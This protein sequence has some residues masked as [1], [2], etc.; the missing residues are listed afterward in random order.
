MG[1]LLMKGLF[2]KENFVFSSM[3]KEQR[4][5]SWIVFGLLALFFIISSFTFVNMLYSF[6]DI[7]GCIVSGSPDVA[8]K[9]L[10]RNLPLFFSFFMTLWVLLAIHAFFRNVSEEQR[11]KSLKKDAIVVL[12]LSLV[13]FFYVVIGRFAGLYSNFAE[14]SPS[15]WFPLDAMLYSLPFIAVSTVTLLDGPALLKDHPYTV[16]SRGPIVTKGRFPYCLFIVLWMLFALYG[17]SGFFMGLFILDF[18]H[19]YLAYS[20]AL[21]LVFLLDASSFIVW[22]LYYNQ[23]KAEKRKELLL[24]LGII[25]V[26]VSVLVA[27]FYFIALGNNL[28][29]P[30]N[31]GFGLLPVAFAAS[32]NIATL[33][34]VATPLI[35]S[36]VALIK[37]ILL[38]KQK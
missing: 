38:K 31:V 27:G 3:D 5:Q 10:V 15:P 16:P 4:K 18:V 30:S 33:L 25:G 2:N 35:A 26:V 34:C 21:L 28:D 36:I 11:M 19:G 6:T 9:D 24:P 22:E 1:E 12:A 23:I 7:I 29:G 17:F 14:G 13:N 8:I 32:V 20:I 37:G